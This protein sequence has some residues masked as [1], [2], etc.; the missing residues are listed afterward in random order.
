F[1]L[2]AGTVVRGEIFAR[3]NWAK[4]YNVTVSVFDSRGNLLDKVFSDG[5]GLY[6]LAGLGTGS[7][8]FGYDAMTTK[9]GDAEY[10]SEFFERQATL[11]HAMPASVVAGDRPRRIDVAHEQKPVVRSVATAATLPD[12]ITVSFQHTFTPTFALNGG[13]TWTTF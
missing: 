9:F 5:Q 7:Y 11:D 8:R 10:F 3:E 6:E 13:T 2:E 1:Q 12:A 4:L